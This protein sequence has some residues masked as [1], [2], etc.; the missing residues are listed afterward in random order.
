MIEQ[1][2][3]YEKE[4]AGLLREPRRCSP[5][6]ACL[7]SAAFSLSLKF[8]N[9]QRG[10]PGGHAELPCRRVR[11]P[12]SREGGGGWGNGGRET[13]AVEVEQRLEVQM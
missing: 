7:G 3:R 8:M 10:A 1:S 9:I 12:M 6:R 11:Q 2:N 13:I 5:A 4:W